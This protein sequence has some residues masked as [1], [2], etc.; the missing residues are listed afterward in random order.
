MLVSCSKWSGFDGSYLQWT[1]RMHENQWQSRQK[2]KQL[3]S[4]RS[5]GEELLC[6]SGIRF[7]RKSHCYFSTAG[8]T[9]SFSS[10]FPI[11]CLLY[12]IAGED[13]SANILHGFLTDK[14]NPAFGARG[15][16]RPQ[17]WASRS[18][19]PLCPGCSLQVLFVA[20]ND[21][22]SQYLNSCRP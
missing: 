6:V 10:S 21:R 15:G 13:V 4:V 16:D 12:M 17:R 3:C 8:S 22:V 7:Q 1:C 2:T 20:A 14:Y 18:P 19:A 9:S 11:V 5:L